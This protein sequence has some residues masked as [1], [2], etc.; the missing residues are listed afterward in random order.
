M[1]ALAPAVL[2]VEDD[3]ADADLLL[4]AL[5]K[6]GFEN[7]VHLVHS[8]DQAKAYLQGEQ[9][10]SDRHQYPLPA[11]VILDHRMPDSSGWEVLEWMRDKPGLKNL[12]VVVFSGSGTP[13][14]QTR[15]LALG[16][17]FETKPVRPEDYRAV[18][19]RI[20]DFWL[21]PGLGLEHFQD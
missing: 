2:I 12:P 9:A 17:A 14:D 4:R 20:G 7:S 13:A 5:R 11:L 3:H 6:C 15:A 16:A 19:K 10:F 18:V 1:S 21:R 8:T